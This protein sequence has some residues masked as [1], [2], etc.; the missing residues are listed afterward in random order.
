M[1][2]LLTFFASIVFVLCIAKPVHAIN[3]SYTFDSLDEAKGY[4]PFVINS[5][6]IDEFEIAEVK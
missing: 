4:M 1:K 5:E 3:F 6:N 2:K